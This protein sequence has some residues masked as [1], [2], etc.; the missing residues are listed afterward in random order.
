MIVHSS[1]LG[2][3]TVRPDDLISFPAGFIGLPEWQSAALAPFSPEVP[4]LQ[5]LQFTHDADAAFL[6]LDIA[7]FAP[8]YDVALAR[9]VAELKETS[10][11]FTIVSVPSGD[12]SRAT[13]NLLAPVVIEPNPAGSPVGKQVILHDTA[14]PLRHSLFRSDD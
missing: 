6:L 11:V 13:T 3:V 7:Q 1:R 14:Y 5:W 12:F 4:L 10:H 8:D 9:Q 2:E